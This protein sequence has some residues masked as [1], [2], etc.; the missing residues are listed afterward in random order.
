MDLTGRFQE[1]EQ[2]GEGSDHLLGLEFSG[3]K[4]ELNEPVQIR[5]VKKIKKIKK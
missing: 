4:H 5:G 1:G 2:T 3:D